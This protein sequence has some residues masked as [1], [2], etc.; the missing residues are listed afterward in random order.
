MEN[1]IDHIG[2]LTGNIAATAK[3]FE[4]LGYQ[5][6]EIV[7]DDTQ[8]TR[9]CFLTKANEVRVELVEPYEDNRTMQKMLTKQGVSPYHTCYE[10]DDVDREYEQLIQEDW[11]ALFKPVAAP[12]FGNRKIFYFWNAEI[13]FIELVNKQ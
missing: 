10:V 11:V 4:K 5:M 8:R 6:G 1:K 2:Y 13:G 9:I 12:A 7:N 3:A